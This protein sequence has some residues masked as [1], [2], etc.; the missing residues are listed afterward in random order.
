M[1]DHGAPDPGSYALA[2]TLL[3]V[4]AVGLCIIGVNLLVSCEATTTAPFG[5]PITTCVYGFQGYGIEFLYG[6][7]LTALASG[8]MFLQ[9]RA[10]RGHLLTWDFQMFL[11]IVAAVIT[12]LFFVAMLVLGLL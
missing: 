4:A 5:Q 11:V 1:T 12:V 3:L 9:F 2:A 7:A 8:G 6:G 10:T